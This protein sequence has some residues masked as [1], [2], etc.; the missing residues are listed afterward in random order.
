M[1]DAQSF[2]ERVVPQLAKLQTESNLAYWEASRTGAK[3]AEA[4]LVA[5]ESALRL[6]FADRKAFAELQSLLARAD[7]WDALT[8]RQLHLLRDH[9]LPNQLDPAVIQ[10]LVR[11]ESELT[12]LFAGFR[13]TLDSGEV[14]DNELKRI[15]REENDSARREKAW[16]ASKQI[17]EAAAPKVLGLV[18][19]RNE[20]ARS[21]GYPDYYRFALATAELDEAELFRTLERLKAVTDEPFRQAKAKLDQRLAARFGLSVADLRP[22]HYADPFFQEAPAGEVALDPYFRDQDVVALAQQYYAGIGLEIGDVIARSDLYERPGKEQHAYC[23]DIDREGDVRVL[24]NVH[25]TMGWAETT[26]HE[27][28]HAVYSKYADR[29]LPYLLRDAAHI[30]TTEAIAMLM[31]RLVTDPRW[32]SQVRGLPDEVARQIA[33]PAREA[34][35]LNELIFVRWGLVVVFFERE[36]YRNPQQDLVRL[37]KETVESLQF[38]TYPQGRQAPD[39]AAKIHLAAFPAYYQNYLLGTLAASQF[40]W[41]VRQELGQDA[42]VGTPATGAFLRERIFAPGARWSWNE[43]I[44]RATGR[45]LDPDI[46]IAEFVAPS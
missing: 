3:E 13:A 41:A 19:L 31:G 34:L 27:M 35:R 44:R 14:T 38:L 37:W 7:E 30:L 11:R 21:L 22:W 42:L 15:L 43:L 12:S 17:G 6:F 25:P 18:E 36:L 1:T 24:E 40:G 4:R 10:E 16:T 20:A 32:L 39:W 45:P 33:E 46:F 8:L 9:Y 2:L 26:M 5:A 29:T 28:G 23:T